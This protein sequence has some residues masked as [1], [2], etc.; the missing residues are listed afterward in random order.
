[1]G[2]IIYIAIALM[3]YGARLIYKFYKGYGIGSYSKEL[4][5]SKIESVAVGPVELKGDIVPIKKTLI[6]DFF[7]KKCVYTRLIIESYGGLG[8]RNK[9]VKK[10]DKERY[11]RF[12]LKDDTGSILVYPKGIEV[13]TQDK[14]IERNN[15]I[16]KNE[17]DEDNKIF[18]EVCY[19]NNISTQDLFRKKKLRIKE[20]NIPIDAKSIYILGNASIDSYKEKTKAGELVIKEKKDVPYFMSDSSEKQI[21]GEFGRG[22]Q[23]IGGIVFVLIGLG[24]L[25]FFMQATNDYINDS[26]DNSFNYSMCANAS[27]MDSNEFFIKCVAENEGRSGYGDRYG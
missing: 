16:L 7:K 13:H 23:L 15:Y 18:D 19:M 11:E 10:V 5:T 9:W 26:I 4:P 24:L 8:E 17:D 22:H 14:Y 12:K 27:S 1:M 3:L 25:F 20:I 2:I 21:H 6:S